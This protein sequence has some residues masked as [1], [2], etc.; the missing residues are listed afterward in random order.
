MRQLP[1]I[2]IVRTQA[3]SNR[4]QYLLGD[5]TDF[6]FSAMAWQGHILNFNEPRFFQLINISLYRASITMQSLRK[7]SDRPCTLPYLS[8]KRQFCGRDQARH[9]FRIFKGDY[10]F[11]RNGLALISK[12]GDKLPTLEKVRRSL[13][14]DHSSHFLPFLLNAV[15]SASKRSS[16][17]SKLRNSTVS[18][19]PL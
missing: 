7:L 10:V 14:L 16:M 15:Q 19:L 9:V 6:F 12:F 3:T 1:D 8:E 17:S 5:R 4:Q 11:S 18:A 2:V 13:D